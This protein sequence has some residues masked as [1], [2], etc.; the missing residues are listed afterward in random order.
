[1]IKRI[2]QFYRAVT[3]DL[4]EDDRAF[5][6]K[7]LSVQETALFYKMNVYDQR[8]VINV[9]YSAEKLAKKG[10]IDK[11]LL[12]RAALL[13]DVGR[14]ADFI[15][16]WDKVV[17]VLLSAMPAVFLQKAA[18]S[19]RGGFIGRRRKALYICLNHAEVGAQKLEQI[20]Q[21][22]LAQIVRRHHDK[23]SKDDSEELTLLRRAD[24]IN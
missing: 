9:A 23:P 7:Y 2:K 1:M 19:G 16:L 17:F 5:L 22:K 13:H 11:S 14:S 10:K 21:I 20:G 4:S 3:A 8:H 12:L 24:E 6:K 15:C 18:K